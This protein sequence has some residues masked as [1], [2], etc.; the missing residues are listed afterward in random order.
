MSVED[1]EEESPDLHWLDCHHQAGLVLPQPPSVFIVLNLL[2]PVLLVFLVEGQPGGVL[3]P[4]GA[5]D[6][7]LF[8][9]GDRQAGEGGGQVDR[10]RLRQLTMLILEVIVRSGEGVR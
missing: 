1:F 8:G 5:A 10:H 2:L 7:C 3:P 6:H 4:P 9:P